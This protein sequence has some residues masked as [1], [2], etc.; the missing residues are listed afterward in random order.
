MSL[1]DVAAVADLVLSEAREAA[2]PR[3]DHGPGGT[4]FSRE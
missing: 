4:T 3:W 1:N 2:S